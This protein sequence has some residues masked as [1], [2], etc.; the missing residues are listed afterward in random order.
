MRSFFNDGGN[1]VI[2]QGN[3][4]TLMKGN[5]NIKQRGPLGK[6]LPRKMTTT[7]RVGSQQWCPFRI[8]MYYY[9]SDGHCYLSTNGN[10]QNFHNGLI[11]SHHHDERQTVVI[12]SRTDMDE[13]TEKRNWELCIY[14][15]LNVLHSQYTLLVRT[16][17]CLQPLI[18]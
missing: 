18:K 5:R 11:F 7:L 1:N 17:S 15:V 10:V 2:A 8:N 6:T 16:R 9:K 14:R 13:H 3:K 12:S 4:S